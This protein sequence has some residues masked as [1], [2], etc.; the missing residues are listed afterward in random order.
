MKT[1][2]TTVAAISLVATGANAFQANNPPRQKSA[3]QYNQQLEKLPNEKRVNVDG[4]LVTTWNDEFN[5]KQSVAIAKVDSKGGMAFRC[6]GGESM[7]LLLA[8]QVKQGE[9]YDVEFHFDQNPV[10]QSNALA[11]TGGT[12]E[13]IAGGT[14]HAMERFLTEFASAKLIRYRLTLNNVETMFK[15]ELPGNNANVISQ[16]L[17]ACKDMPVDSETSDNG[18]GGRDA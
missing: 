16:V 18:K 14:E 12:L 10:F 17:K 6:W 13:I 4:W 1:L 2:L 9:R 8:A 3:P 7:A 5:D 15:L 11:I